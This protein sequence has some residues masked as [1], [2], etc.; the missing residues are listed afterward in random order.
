[1]KKEKTTPKKRASNTGYG[2]S[3]RKATL[4][5][6]AKDLKPEAKEEKPVIDKKALKKKMEEKLSPQE[7]YFCELYVSDVEFYG[8]GTQSYI[9]AFDIT[10]V[11]GKS[12]N[13]TDDNE[14]TYEA[15]R[16]AAHKL[17]TNT[18]ILNRID[19]LLEE[20]GFNDQQAD[21]TLQFLMTQRADLR[22]ALGAAE[23]YNKL[24]ARIQDKQHVL[25]SFATEEMSDAE[26]MEAIKKKQAFFNKE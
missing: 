20:G 12:R 9:E 21:K 18:N 13:E 22:V 24:K 26:L 17:L 16:V 25:H 6:A 2:K 5:N 4:K 11:K 10:V 23:A 7:E 8:N 15:V 14:M 19:E 3:G 1:M